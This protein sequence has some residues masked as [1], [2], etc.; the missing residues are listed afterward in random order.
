MSKFGVIARFES[1]ESLVHAAEKVRD[2]GFTKFDCHSPFPI[3]GMDDAMGLKRSKLGYLI[4]AMG[5]TGALFGF[6]LQTWIHSIEYPMN[7]SGKPYFA[8][9]AYAIITFV[10]QDSITLFFI[11][12]NFQM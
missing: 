4:G 8:Y 9:P 1:P 10:F 3:H 6:G 12:K 7:I 5:L 11:P 2:K